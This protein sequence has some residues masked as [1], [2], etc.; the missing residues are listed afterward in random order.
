M[1]QQDCTKKKC[2]WL[3]RLTDYAINDRFLKMEQQWSVQDDFRSLTVWGKTL[4][5]GLAAWRRK[6]LQLLSDDGGV[7][8]LRAG[9]PLSF[10]LILHLFVW[11]G[12]SNILHFHFRIH[13]HKYVYVPSLYLWR[14]NSPRCPARPYPSSRAYSC[15]SLFLPRSLTANQRTNNVDCLFPFIPFSDRKTPH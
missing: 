8:V 9:R 7:N 3:I 14:K 10:K 15:P 5:C 11:R 12:H 6:L 4:P 1:R 2:C 13:T